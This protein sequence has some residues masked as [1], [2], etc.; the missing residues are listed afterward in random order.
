MITDQ[1]LAS[2]WRQ[3]KINNECFAQV[4]PG[5][6]GDTIPDEYI[7]HPDWCRES[8]ND[9]W[10]TLMAAEQIKGANMT[11]DKLRRSVRDDKAIRSTSEAS[12]AQV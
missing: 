6:V 10:R 9:H 12:A 3:I 7:F 11:E 8:I 4:P 1:V 2:G 5:F